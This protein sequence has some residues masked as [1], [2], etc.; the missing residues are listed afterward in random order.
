MKNRMPDAAEKPIF[1][2]GQTRM[3]SVYSH[4]LILLRLLLI[5]RSLS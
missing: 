5:L 2:G 4:W 1:P 3:F